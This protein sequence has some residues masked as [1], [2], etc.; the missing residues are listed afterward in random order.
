MP[1]FRCHLVEL[2][3]IFVV[4]FPP[5]MLFWLQQVQ[6]LRNVIFLFV[7]GRLA[8]QGS[9]LKHHLDLLLVGLDNGASHVHTFAALGGELS[10][11]NLR[12][13]AGGVGAGAHLVE[14]VCPPA[15]DPTLGGWYTLRGVLGWPGVDSCS[16]KL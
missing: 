6:A 13:G 5:P 11:D 3:A 10:P 8:V 4:V 7:G 12:F 2:V 14:A 16:C 1:T 15:A 9:G